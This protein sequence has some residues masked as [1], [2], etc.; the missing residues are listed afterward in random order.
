MLG[1]A[2]CTLALLFAGVVSI[3]PSVRAEQAEDLFELPLE[4]LEQMVV[5]AQKRTENLQEVPLSIA[6]FS[7]EDL[8]RFGIYDT[9]SLQTA[10]PGLV[11]NNTGSSAQPYL[12]GVGT[13]FAFAGLEPSVA[14]YVDD[15]YLARAQATIFELADIERIEVLRG[16]QGTLYGRNATG[17]AIRVLTRGVDEEV[18]GN[19]TATLGNYDTRAISGT[20]NLPVSSTFGTRLTA[21]IRKRDGYADNLEP[22]GVPELDDRDVTVLRGKFRWDISDR[23]SSLLTLQYSD[24]EDNV[25]NDLIDL[26]PPGLNLGI[27]A[28]GI[29]GTSR[30]E[31]ATAIDSIIEDEQLSLDLRFD[32]NLTGFDFVSITGYHDFEQNTS[33]DADGTS[34]PEIDAVQVP[35]EA[36]AFSQEFQLLSVSDG[37]WDWITGLYF[38]DETADFEVILDRDGDTL[39]SQGDQRA[40]TTAFALFGQ[41]TYEFNPNWSLTLGARWSYE[42][43]K[44]RVRESTIA[45]ATLVPVP[46]ADEDDWSELTPKLTLV[47][48]IEPGMF[49]LTYARG[50]KSGGFNYAA[51]AGSGVP[52]DPEILDMFELGWKTTH[53]DGR[54]QLSGSLFYY[55]YKDLQVTRVVAGT[56][57]TVTENAADAEAL[58]LDLEIAWAP[59]DWMHLTAGLSLLDSKYKEFDASATVFNAALSGVPDEPGMSTV[60][61]DASGE[62]LLRAPDASLFLSAVVEI[63]LGSIRAPVTVTYS[64]KDDYLF[65]FVAD[66]STERLVQNSYGLLTARATLTTAGDAWSFSIWGNNL[67]NEEDYYMDIVANAAGIRG[68]PGAPRTWGVDLTFRF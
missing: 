20:V 27:A 15:R 28:G 62:S 50:F 36:Q 55:D 67:T 47:R 6:A 53:A 24:Q 10:T 59:S 31:V 3:A 35:Q 23:V 46:F 60:L 2:R 33:T 32:V 4:E 42:E 9:Q 48:R 64:Y 52:L 18:S 11:F 44:V 66:P 39:E 41:A 40:E 43:K 49:Y 25:G 56:G 7:G 34:A 57:V 8:T 30:G 58:G 38:F 26:S 65:D 68:S 5:T 37:P 29:S 45:G 17:G 61:F 13:R 16:P 1:G 14:T 63:P 51:S 12:R 21:L 54:L 19:I 22:S